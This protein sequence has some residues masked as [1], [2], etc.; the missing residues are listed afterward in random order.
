MA[1]QEG[2]YDKLFKD[3][4]PAGLQK[5]QLDL[6]PRGKYKEV[7]ELTKKIHNSLLSKKLIALEE[8]KNLVDAIAIPFLVSTY[9]FGCSEKSLLSMLPETG[10][11]WYPVVLHAAPDYSIKTS[12]HDKHHMRA[13]IDKEDVEKMHNAFYLQ[14]ERPRAEHACA[15]CVSLP[16]IVIRFRD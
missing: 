16:Y 1:D 4:V 13:L 14:I 6:I 8:L 2:I 9:E 12:F 15:V 10:Y 5:E 11:T 3:R 7:K